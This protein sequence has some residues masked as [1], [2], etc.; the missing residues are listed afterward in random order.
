M[1]TRSTGGI[2]WP[3]QRRAGIAAAARPL[4]ARPGPRSSFRAAAGPSS[5]RRATATRY[6]NGGTKTCVETGVR[7]DD[8]GGDRR[9]RRAH[10]RRQHR[11]ARS[12]RHERRLRRAAERR[13]RRAARLLLHARPDEAG[14]RRGRARGRQDAVARRQGGDGADR[15]SPAR[16]QGRADV[17]A[18]PGL[19]DPAGS[20][21]AATRA[22]QWLE[23]KQRTDPL[24]Y[25]KDPRRAR[26]GRARGDP[27]HGRRGPHRREPHLRHDQL[28]RRERAG[29]RL[30][31]DDDERAGVEDS[32]AARRLADSR[33]RAV[34]GRRRRRRGIDRT[35]RSQSL[36]PVLVPDRRGDAARRSPKDA[37]HG[38]AAAASRTTRSRS[39]C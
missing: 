18:Q 34:R 24:H 7:N 8:D 15:P 22:R 25:I 31:R 17:R 38:S 13:R 21:H 35:R 16:R 11:R 33:R 5:S 28:R 1:A 2:S 6:K 36:Q 20:Q 39:G 23:W 19:R 26:G 10:R 30:R 29:R 4:A 27:R 9:A 32:R 14:R 3:R 12:A 37:G